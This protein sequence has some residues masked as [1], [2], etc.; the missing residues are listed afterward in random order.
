MLPIGV[1]SPGYIAESDEKARED[2]WPCY[3]GMRDR[4][5]AE[6]G[7]PPST[8]REFDSE[9]EMGSAYVGSAETVAKKI[10]ATCKVL[11][12]ARFEMKYSSGTLPHEQMM[13]SIELYGR[14][15]IPRVREL[16][17]AA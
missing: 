3:K 4:I 13:R 15:V 17:A 11:G 5:G 12:L 9:V 7:W 6:R 14:N 16:M 8:R 10:A 1:H 2:Y